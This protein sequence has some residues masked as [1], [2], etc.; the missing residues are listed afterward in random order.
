[1]VCV[2]VCMCRGVCVCVCVCHWVWSGTTIILYTY[3]EYVEEDR[4]RIIERKKERK[5]LYPDRRVSS[6]KIKADPTIKMSGFL[7]LELSGSVSRQHTKQKTPMGCLS[8]G[9]QCDLD[10]RVT[11][12][13]MWQQYRQCVPCVLRISIR[14]T[15]HMVRALWRVA[16]TNCVVETDMITVSYSRDQRQELSR[17]QYPQLPCDQWREIRCDP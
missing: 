15:E 6:L 16:N 1:V 5:E 2:C 17:D 7:R 3:N 8:K 4:L 13:N 12:V 11:T 10:M 9:R 14:Q